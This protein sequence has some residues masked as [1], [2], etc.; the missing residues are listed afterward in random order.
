M[1]EFLYG[2]NPTQ[3]HTT[4]QFTLGTESRDPR[5]R[6]FPQNV[7]RYVRAAGTITAGLAVT[8]ASDNTNEPNAVVATSATGQSLYG[9]ALSSIDSQTNLFGWVAIKGHV[10]SVLSGGTWAQGDVLASSGTAGALIALATNASAS[11]DVIAAIGGVRI[12]AVD[13]ASAAGT[14]EVLIY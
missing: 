1:A 11:A 14:A 5:A 12:S 9:I 10:T 13:T 7:V 2:V 4:A 8:L 3:T 6:T